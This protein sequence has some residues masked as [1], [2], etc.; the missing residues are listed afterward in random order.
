MCDVLN[1][2][3]LLFTL[4]FLYCYYLF[5]HLLNTHQILLPLLSNFNKHCNVSTVSYF[6]AVVCIRN[7]IT[8]DCD[9]GILFIIFIFIATQSFPLHLTQIQYSAYDCRIYLCFHSV[10]CY[11]YSDLSVLFC[12]NFRAQIVLL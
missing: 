6:C 4:I 1:L 10:F 9:I 8:N 11:I 7:S 12:V 5:I 2:F 3:E